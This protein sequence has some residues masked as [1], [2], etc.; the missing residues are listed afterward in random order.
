MLAVC[1]AYVQI[2]HTFLYVIQTGICDYLSYTLSRP[3]KYYSQVSLAR[4]FYVRSLNRWSLIKLFTF[5]WRCPLNQSHD[6][7]SNGNNNIETQNYHKY[8]GGTQALF[9]I[10][11]PDIHVV[12]A[13]FLL[14]HIFISVPAETSWQ[15][16]RN[17]GEHKLAHKYEYRPS[18][19]YIIVSRHLELIGEKIVAF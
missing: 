2:S 9:Q 7:K 6:F 3:D 13:L 15:P 4:Q 17:K 8:I 11:P 1:Q 19:F 5:S 14:T 12:K 10:N 16:Q 18:F